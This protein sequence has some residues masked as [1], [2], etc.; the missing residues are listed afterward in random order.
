MPERDLTAITPNVGALIQ[1]T[2]VRGLSA[3][4]KQR[5]SV[6]GACSPRTMYSLIHLASESTAKSLSSVG[7]RFPRNKIKIIAPAPLP[8]QSIL[9]AV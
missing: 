2:S 8:Y 3:C 5:C 4:A 6:L 7:P 9:K 1:V